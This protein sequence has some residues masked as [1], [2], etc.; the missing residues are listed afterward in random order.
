MSEENKL[1]VLELINKCAADEEYKDKVTVLPLMCGTG[2]ST[3]ISY[4][5]RECIE[6]NSGL[7]VVT[8]RKKRLEE[9]F[10]PRDAELKQY[11]DKN[12]NKIALLVSGK[13]L[14]VEL[15][16]MHSCPILLMTTQRYFSLERDELIDKYLKWKNGQRSLIIFDEMPEL[17][18]DYKLD[19]SSIN[20]LDSVLYECVIDNPGERYENRN[21]FNSS[22]WNELRLRFLTDIVPVFKTDKHNYCRL[23][24]R[25]SNDVLTPAE[26]TELPY[27][28]LKS[29]I[30]VE[31]FK[32]E[33]YI[34]KLEKKYNSTILI[35]LDEPYA[36]SIIS[37]WYTDII[38]D[39]SDD[40]V[41]VEIAQGQ[42]NTIEQSFS[43]S[44]IDQF[45]RDNR[46]NIISIDSKA[47]KTYRA[48]MYFM[49]NDTI[50]TFRDITTGKK[51]IYYQITMSNK[52]LLSDLGSKVIILDGTADLTPDYNQDYIHMIDCSSYIRQLPNLHIR[53]INESSSRQKI[54]DKVS[55]N[56]AYFKT[57]WEYL[58]QQT[59]DD[60]P[61]IFTYKDISD[62]T[63]CEIESEAKNAASDELR[64]NKETA[65]NEDEFDP[66]E[67]MPGYL[68]NLR[69][70]N[71]F[72]N[73]RVFG[74]VGLLIKP[75]SYYVSHYLDRDES[76]RAELSELNMFYPES[77]EALDKVLK[78]TE[79]K[80]VMYND[81]LADIEQNVFRAPIR[82]ANYTGEVYYYLF[83]DTQTY[84]DIADL[85]ADR[86]KNVYGADVE[87]IEDP[88]EFRSCIESQKIRDGKPTVA[89][90]C[91]N[92]II[93]QQNG[94]HFTTSDM[95][96]ALGL[97][98]KDVSKAIAKNKILKQKLNSMRDPN[99]KIGHYIIRK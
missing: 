24:P 23:H 71:E 29:I 63:S 94:T 32:K 43:V 62:I 91:L 49:Y 80:S 16:R 95:A 73:Y 90:Q 81:I 83:F 78:T 10:D 4:K 46:S 67:A 79:Y 12:K 77:I 42:L 18:T 92:W 54:Y 41:A 59:N 58:R 14:A 99:Y 72:L 31:K 56:T 68:G 86:F 93:G 21:G 5:I 65:K 70:L 15:K 45:C 17:Y 1:T 66:S 11:L 96:S 40:K 27:Y 97:K 53:I 89:S 88:L 9:Y 75:P 35:M 85:I 7:L 48:L 20:Q 82:L 22:G 6:E 28:D 84:R 33:Y 57:I 74:Q 30:N 34:D 47:Y 98:S 52:S 51:E 36:G 37:R 2:K 60:N 44:Y 50:Y 13:K 61:A 26:M 3:A 19:I 8:D 25:T 76:L 64:Q 69:G 39:D 38:P 55:D 87:I